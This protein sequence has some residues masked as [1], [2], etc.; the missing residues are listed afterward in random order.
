M[1]VQTD[2]VVTTAHHRLTLLPD[3]GDMLDM[4]YAAIDGA[5]R[6]VLLECYIFADDAAVA[7]M[8]LASMEPRRRRRGNRPPSYR[9]I[10]QVY[11]E[12]NASGVTP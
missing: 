6:Q 7:P 3:M 12:T 11:T 9:T 10:Q 8:R 2:D 1:P 5:R 4:V